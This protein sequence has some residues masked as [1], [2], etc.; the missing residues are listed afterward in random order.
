MDHKK[1]YFFTKWK[2]NFYKKMWEEHRAQFIFLIIRT[3]QDLSESKG[4][5]IDV[6]NMRWLPLPHTL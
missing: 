6:A 5:K 1:S 4:S 3:S 2:Q